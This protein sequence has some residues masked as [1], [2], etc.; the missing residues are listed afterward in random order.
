MSEKF[1]I[2]KSVDQGMMMADSRTDWATGA[3]AIY[4][5]RVKTRSRASKNIETDFEKPN[6]GARGG[7]LWDNKPAM[8]R[9]EMYE[10][11]NQQ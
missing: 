3:M 8:I 10:F 4:I 5:T 6:Y 11:R 1:E 2:R 9:D 7:T